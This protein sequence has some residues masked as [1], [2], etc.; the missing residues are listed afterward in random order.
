[1]VGMRGHVTYY[2]N[3][4]GDHASARYWATTFASALGVDVITLCVPDGWII[5][6]HALLL[7][8]YMD[9]HPQYSGDNAQEAERE[10][11]TDVW[12]EVGAEISEDQEAYARSDEDGWF[13][14]D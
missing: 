14:D 11:D 7:S 5:K 13:C 6:D 1:M 3:I 9:L 4:I 2:P 8:M 10:Y 12:Q